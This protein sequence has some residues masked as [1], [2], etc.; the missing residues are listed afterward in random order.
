VALLAGSLSALGFYP[1]LL[2]F[3]IITIGSFLGDS[4]GIFIGKHFKNAKW[5]QKIMQ[6]E[7][8][9]KTLKAF[10]ENIP[11]IAILGKLIPGVRSTPSLF[12]GV[13]GVSFRSYA[14]YSFIGSALWS[15]IGVFGGNVLARY[16]G[17]NYAIMV[18]LGILLLS[19]IIF[20]VKYLL[21][22]TKK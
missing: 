3:F 12:A 15:F 22:K 9:Q 2:V 21:K 4:I 7:G 17:G 5:I 20:L 10:D 1:P 11:F 6:A 14:L 8:N 13:R 19:I 18:I 16:L